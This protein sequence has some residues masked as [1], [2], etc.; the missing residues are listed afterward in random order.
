M[1]LEPIWFVSEEY[2][3]HTFTRSATSG[4]GEELPFRS[5][6]LWKQG[7]KPHASEN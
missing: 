1:G 4:C 7:Y 2:C 5:I 3:Q 6:H